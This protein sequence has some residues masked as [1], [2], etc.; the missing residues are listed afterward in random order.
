M[1]ALWRQGDIGN[2][3]PLSKFPTGRSWKRSPA[4]RR[5]T[6][7]CCKLVNV[8][9]QQIVSIV[10]DSWIS[11]VAVNLLGCLFSRD[12]RL[13]VYLKNFH[14]NVWFTDFSFLFGNWRLEWKVIISQVATRHN[15]SFISLGN[16]KTC[17]NVNTTSLGIMS[18][19]N[20]SVD[21]ASGLFK[22]MIPRARV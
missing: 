6:Q 2:D 8:A 17:N 1:I 16:N 15:T 4:C 12:S 18:L 7:W 21:T 3:G 5:I 19:I 22:P 20:G 14:L 9:V 10:T 13:E 11:T